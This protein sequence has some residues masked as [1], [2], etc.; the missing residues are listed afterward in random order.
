MDKTLPMSETN[1]DPFNRSFKAK[2]K[3][4]RD[5]A[6]GHQVMVVHSIVDVT[7]KPPSTCKGAERITKMLEE[8]AIDRKSAEEPPAI[9]FGKKEREYRVLKHPGTVSGLK[10]TDMMELL[11][12][13]EI[14]SLILCG[15][16]T[17]GAILR[18]AV[19]ATDEGFVVS[20]I[21]DACC[22]PVD[23]LHD[24]LMK[25]VLPSRTHVATAELF[26]KEWAKEI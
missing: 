10:S 21:E 2:G 3:T 1:A 11:S 8:I 9:A 25:S 19:P 23:G 4:M 16:S 18:T 5:W 13:H 6:F 7:G 24:T 14:K 12:I 22:D 15:I 20:V 17:S 26:M